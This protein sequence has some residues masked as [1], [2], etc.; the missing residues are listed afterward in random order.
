MKRTRLRFLVALT[1]MVLAVAVVASHRAIPKAIAQNF[2]KCQPCKDQ[3]F[4]TYKQ[5][6]I[7]ACTKT[8]GV[9]DTQSGECNKSQDLQR[10][11]A[12]AELCDKAYKDSVSRCPCR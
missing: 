10:Y 5:C 1:I 8:G 4:R 2:S 7:N 6:L 11:R 3:A 9:F 12:L